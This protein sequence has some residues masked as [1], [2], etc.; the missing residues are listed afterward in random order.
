LNLPKPLSEFA[1]DEQHPDDVRRLVRTEVPSFAANSLKASFSAAGLK[2]GNVVDTRLPP[3][4]TN[5]NLQGITTNRPHPAPRRIKSHMVPRQPA[6]GLAPAAAKIEPP[7]E[8][9][10]RNQQMT[11]RC[12]PTHDRRRKRNSIL[13]LQIDQLHFTNLHIIQI[14]IIKFSPSKSESIIKSHALQPHF[15][16]RPSESIISRDPPSF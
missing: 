7:E 16:F 15:K 1:G 2:K 5:N 11:P 10:P 13:L 3:F 9:A 14:F 6:E 4:G 12:P 8:R